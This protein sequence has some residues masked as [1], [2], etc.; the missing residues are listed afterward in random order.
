MISSSSR[1]RQIASHRARESGSA[2]GLSD[3]SAQSSAPPRPIKKHTSL[4]A[5]S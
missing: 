2:A 4:M 1:W 3:A 5:A